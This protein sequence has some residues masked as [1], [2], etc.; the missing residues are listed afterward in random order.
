MFLSN[1]TYDDYPYYLHEDRV[2]TEVEIENI[3]PTQTKKA[4]N[5]GRVPATTSLTAGNTLY[6]FKMPTPA[7]FVRFFT[8]PS[9]IISKK[10]GKLVKSGLKGTRKDALS[11]MI[12]STMG[13]DMTMEV[14]NRPEFV[15]RVKDLSLIELNP[16]IETVDKPSVEVVKARKEVFDNYVEL[17]AEKIGRDPNQKFS[18]TEFK[19]QIKEESKLFFE[20]KDLFGDKNYQ[21]YKDYFSQGL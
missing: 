11:K 13:K 14:V 5:E 6:K 8:P 16:K 4:I 17:L 21:K 19:D 7:Q 20:N 10:T 3:S 12:G 1:F 9:E 15:A 2:F 18:V